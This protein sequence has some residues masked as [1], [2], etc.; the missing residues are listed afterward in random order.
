MLDRAAVSKVDDRRPVPSHFECRRD[1]L[2]SERLDPEER[3][4]AEAIVPRHRSQQQDMHMTAS[5]AIIRTATDQA[6]P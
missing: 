5:E 2:E 3:T 4:Q 1:V 6:D